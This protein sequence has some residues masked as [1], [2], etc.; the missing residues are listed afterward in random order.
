MKTKISKAQIEVWEWKEKAF[1]ELEKIP[2]KERI[3]YIEA[4]TK[5]IINKLKKKKQELII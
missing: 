1:E 2:E 5:I 3:K 4:K